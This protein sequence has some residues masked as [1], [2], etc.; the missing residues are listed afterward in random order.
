MT[1]DSQLDWWQR[2]DLFY[3]NKKLIF[4]GHNVNKLAYQFG[5]PSFVYSSARIE[6]NLKRIRQALDDAGLAGRSS[7]F[8]A[9]KANRF[10]PLLR[11]LKQTGGC[12]ID[13]CS[14][15][16]VKHAVSCGFQP[17][18]I[19]FTA[20]SLSKNDFAMLD[21]YHGL[22]MDCDTLHAIRS[23]GELNPGS[24]IGIRINPA[25]GI[26]RACNDRLQYAG[27]TT[28]KFGIY[29]EQ[30]EQALEL[31]AEFDLTVSKIHFHTGCGYLTPELD[32]LDHVIS[33]GMKFVADAPD[34][35]RVN[36][37]GG[38]GVPHLPE[39]QALDLAQWSAVLNRHFGKRDL[40][41]EVEPG[42]YIVKDAGLLL[43]AK[44]YVETKRDTLFVGVDAGFN[45][46]PEPA[47]YGLPFQPVTLF[48]DDSPLRPTHV[49]GN[50]NEALDVWYENAPLPD[51]DQHDYLALIN[52][53]AYSSS[54]ASNHCMRGEFSEF[55]LP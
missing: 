54:M 13:A 30:F 2:P 29:R 27:C 12:G 1:G 23:W 47:Y 16:E 5:T 17:S 50:I 24:E 20:T 48:L 51:L 45:I 28:T 22:F 49:V 41:I 6:A 46:A 43:L 33:E 38:L 35:K 10:A 42:D 8:Y 21:R 55:L 25:A 19:S 39:D 26:G 31:A 34:V 3:Q 53:G 7:I 36:I 15:N 32:Q 44:T 9:M 40:H 4:A 14:P 11:F 37:G 52:A 18:E